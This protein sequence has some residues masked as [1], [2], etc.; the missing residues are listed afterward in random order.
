MGYWIT[1]SGSYYE[2]DSADF[3]D[4]AVPQRPSALHVWNGTAWALDIAAYKASAKQTI[5]NAAGARIVA[6]YPLVN[7][8]SPGMQNNMLARKSELD[9]V[10]LT[11][12]TLTPA[13]A[14][15]LQ[16]LRDAWTWIAAVRSAAKTAKLAVDAAANDQASIDAASVVT[17]PATVP[18]IWP[19]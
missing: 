13:E 15:E 3:R 17:W 12:G 1:S 18:P 5:N 19:V 10:R 11:G 8:P 14:A 6:Q 16:V 4:T 7:P 2:G 9:E